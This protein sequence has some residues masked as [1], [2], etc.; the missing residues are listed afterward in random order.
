MA[1]IIFGEVIL[2]PLYYYSTHSV[3]KFICGFSCRAGLPAY[4]VY[5]YV[6]SQFNVFLCVMG[7]V[8]VKW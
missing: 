5:T 1:V 8:G 6:S 2:I 7:W 4:V 3:N